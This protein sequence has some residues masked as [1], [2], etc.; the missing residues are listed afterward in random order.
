MI[1]LTY[2]D[3]YSGIY[4][5][6]VIDVC[7]LLEKELKID[8]RLIA[9]VSLRNF[10]AQ[11]KLIKAELPRATVLPMF[12]KVKNWRSNVS[13][14]KVLGGIQ[15]DDT[16]WARGPFACNMAISLKRQGLAGKIMF[17]ARGAYHAEFNEYKV[18]GD[19][20][21]N[22]EIGAIEKSA[23]KESDA[24]LA[25][26]AKL[27]EWWQQHYNFTPAHYEV[28]PCTLSSDF[29]EPLPHASEL[30]ELRSKLGFSATDVV[31]VYSGSSAGWQSFELID[32]YLFQKM[33]KDPNLKLIFL[34]PHTPPNSKAFKTFSSR[35]L[36][37]WVKP[38]EVRN[39]LLAADYGLLIREDSVTNQVASPVKFA[40]YLSCGLQ[41]IISEQIGDFSSF[42]KENDC[43]MF[44][45]ENK[46]LES[47][48]Y[49]QKDLTHRLA[50]IH[51]SKKSE[52]IQKKYARL[53]AG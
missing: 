52:L 5:S 3:A 1:F 20:S 8:M 31:L 42:V 18:A 27:V 28:I 26:S 23:L 13:V 22:N 6:Q 12:P 9:L 32:D 21:I 15:K 29:E 4:K 47:I 39:I 48:S 19:N 7:K 36:T 40:E 11:R 41:V 46:T 33:T 25:V 50:L 51:F 17:D 49:V 44:H 30:Q 10:R 34:S 16:I 53:L 43:G 35:I 37:K 45:T 2:N 38:S 24:Q 14:L